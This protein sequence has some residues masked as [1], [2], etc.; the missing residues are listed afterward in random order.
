MELVRRLTEHEVTPGT[1][2]TAFS[3]LDWQA[4]QLIPV[5]AYCSII[6]YPFLLQ[7][8]LF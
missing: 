3:T 4:A 1:F 6:V 2:K 7:L 5:T 8:L